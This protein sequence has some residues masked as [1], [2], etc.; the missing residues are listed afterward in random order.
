MRRVGART[1]TNATLASPPDVPAAAHRLERLDPRRHLAAAIGW[2][3]LAVVSLA[4]LVAGHLV[5]VDAERAAR[6]DAQRLVQQFAI[7]VAGALTMSLQTRLAIVQTTGEQI[8]V[9]PPSGARALGRHLS[10][11]ASQFPE[12]EWVGVADRDGRLVGATGAVPDGAEVRRQRWFEA[13]RVAAY[14]G[15]AGGAGAAAPR[16]V[17]IAA[18]IDPS[19]QVIAARLS[20]AWIEGQCRELLASLDASRQV[21]LLLLG[22]DGRVLAGPPGWAGRAVA[23]ADD[24]SE[25]GRY[26]AG[27]RAIVAAP[28][29]DPGWSVVVRQPA[30]AA[31][32]GV[33][34]LRRTVLI[35]VLAAGAV[36]A[37]CSLLL[38]RWLMR[39]LDGLDRQARAMRQGLRADIEAPPGQD[40]VSRIGATL[41]ALVGQLQREKAALA[42]LNAELDARV[43][44]RTARIER[45]ADEARHAAVTRE[46]LRLA[47]DLHDTLAHSLMA[48][49]QQIRLVRKLRDRMSPDE[50]AAE[51]G[52]AEAVA[53][54]GLTE[55]RAAITQM[56]HGSVRDTG[57]ASAL[58]DLLVR[59]GERTGLRTTL[60]AEGPLADLADERAETLFRIAEEALRNVERHARAGTVGVTLGGDGPRGVLSVRDDGVGFDPAAPRPG[61]YG[62][63]GI[64]EQAALIEAVLTV[65]SRPGAGTELR[66][67]FDR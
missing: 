62:L 50:L 37:V 45:M 17:D 20:W 33:Q 23:A 55:A 22:G 24:L 31:L 58:G 21:E 53:A 39:R 44:E 16:G 14:V 35:T 8:A 61:H 6:D 60:A 51:L 34:V 2:A 65:E 1:V 52:R 56:R 67:E 57:L 15:E 59:F 49:L 42:S 29:P 47:R 66:L 54:E 41:S 9:S 13:G 43:V 18:P 64:R 28:G 38:T 27:R 11:V 12:F 30:G 32:A 46:R 25:G 7:Q 4:S 63:V 5:A 10:A 26:V 3:L 48:L 19:T 36:A 40:E